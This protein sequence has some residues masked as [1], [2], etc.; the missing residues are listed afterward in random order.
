ML[1]A[2]AAPAPTPPSAVHPNL[3]DQTSDLNPGGLS[4]ALH[5]MIDESFTVSH[6]TIIYL[7]QLLSDTSRDWVTLVL[8][9]YTVPGLK[10]PII[11]KKYVTYYFQ[12]VNRYF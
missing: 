8:Q 12:I 7:V 6:P 9:K 11:L 4:I 1:P 10:V 2:P 5:T 3:H